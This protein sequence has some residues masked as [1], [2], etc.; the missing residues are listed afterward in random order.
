MQETLN[1]T[2]YTD[3]HTQYK[4]AKQR[5]WSL[6][7][8]K[9]QEIALR[10]G[11]ARKY[12]RI[13]YGDGDVDDKTRLP[14]G[15]R[16]VA[17]TELEVRSPHTV[18]RRARQCRIFERAFPDDEDAY[19]YSQIKLSGQPKIEPTLLQ[20]AIVIGAYLFS[21]WEAI[22]PNGETKRT[23]EHV[24]LAFIFNMFIQLFSNAVH[25]NRPITRNTLKKWICEEQAHNPVLFTLGRKGAKEI[26]KKWMPKQPSDFRAPNECWIMDARV[27]PFY[28][29]HRKK[30]CTVT[31]LLIIDAYSGHIIA[32]HLVA[33]TVTDE[34]GQTRKVDFTADD[35][36]LL[37]LYAIVT[38]GKRP[39][40]LYTDN[41]SQFKAVEPLLPML[42]S[43]TS[44]EII[45]IFGFPGHPWGRGKVEVT[46]REFD[47]ALFKYTGIVRDE[48]DLEAWRKARE[49]AN[50][51]L[52]DLRSVAGKHTE[53]WCDKALDGSR[54]RRDRF[55]ND[56][57]LIL[58]IPSFDRLLY[59][60]CGYKIGEARISGDTANIS[61]RGIYIPKRGLYK[62]A[63]LKDYD[64]W[65]NAAGQGKVLYSIIPLKNEEWIFACLDGKKWERLI[66]IDEQL[67]SR[68][69]HVENQ[70]AAIRVV[71]EQLA[72][73]RDLSIAALTQLGHEVPQISDDDKAI[74]KTIRDSET[75]AKNTSESKDTDTSKTKGRSSGRRKTKDV[76]PLQRDAPHPQLTELEALI[77]QFQSF[78]T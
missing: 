55:E 37:L 49:S 68:Q 51:K 66:A 9:R 12:A 72:E 34:T 53:R 39:K 76:T 1:T 67:Q 78:E 11:Y 46:L 2:L 13:L 45:M 42:A 62:P 36:R 54:T 15:M 41:G 3:I 5:Y 63:T 28:I 60:G 71:R 22:L 25:R 44:D 23:R 26:W 8:E 56:N 6:S 21:D 27:L 57:P 74:F 52:D 7:A 70:W 73:L 65:L 31:L 38:H 35:V 20:R 14:N 48:D 16:Q 24:L 61:G 59:L 4:A 47:K 33:R 17:M 30:R 43:G 18:E 40:Y 69:T 32:W 29:R 77:E 50:F 10:A 58:S 19:I 75:S 64:N